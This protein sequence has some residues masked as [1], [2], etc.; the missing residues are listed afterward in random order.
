MEEEKE[1]WEGGGLRQTQA[2]VFTLKIRM[3]TG[4]V[5]INTIGTLSKYVTSE[6]K[7]KVH[8]DL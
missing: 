6:V 7:G 3:R 1:E 8:A 5:K 4:N 2:M